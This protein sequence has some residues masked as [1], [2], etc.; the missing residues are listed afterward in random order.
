VRDQL[1][2]VNS[3]ASSLYLHGNPRRGWASH[4]SPAVLKK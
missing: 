1:G 2:H 4:I 3:A